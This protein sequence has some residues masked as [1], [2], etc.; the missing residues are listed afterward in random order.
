MPTEASSALMINLRVLMSQNAYQGGIYVRRG[1]T[2]RYTSLTPLKH[3]L[4][5][6][7]RNLVNF[8]V[9]VLLK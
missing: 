8:V 7:P 4:T 9:L 5:Y 1:I 3:S 6:G 2:Y